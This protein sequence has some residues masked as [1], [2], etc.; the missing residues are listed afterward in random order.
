MNVCISSAAAE[1]PSGTFPLL[2][3]R[4]TDGFQTKEYEVAGQDALAEELRALFQTINVNALT[5]IA[6]KLRGGISCFVRPFGYDRASLR[7]AMGA[8]N[9]HL[10]LVFDDGLSWMARL[11]RRNA[12]TLPA[13]VRPCL[14]RSEVATYSFLR[15]ETKVPVPAVFAYALDSNNPVGSGYILME[16]IKGNNLL[17]S[18]PTSGQLSKVLVQLAEI[19]KELYRHPFPLMGSLDTPGSANIGPIVHDL[20]VDLALINGGGRD[21]QQH[22]SF[23]G[24]FINLRDF[25]HELIPRILHMI[26]VGELYPF[27]AVDAFLIHKFLFDLLGRW[28]EDIQETGEFYLRHFDDKGDHIMVDEDFN[29]TGI[30]D[31]EGAYTAQK[32]EAFTSPIALWNSKEFFSERKTLSSS[33]LEFARLLDGASHECAN[34]PTNINLGDCVRLGK[35]FQRFRICVGYTLYDEDMENYRKAFM[36]LLREFDIYSEK[37]WEDWKA[38][39]LKKYSEDEKLA[40]L[41]RREG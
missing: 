6:S 3:L 23:P 20:M 7:S 31:W 26:V 33:E 22:V 41:L 28:S 18:S 25:Y 24:P 2:P 35:I 34:H 12:S 19:Y 29:I 40:S 21:T 5:L 32:T 13:A 37:S 4:L 17:S 36:G 8:I 15:K 14:I 16:T 9:L 30:I 27:W 39:A 38:F 11:K 1:L 10:E